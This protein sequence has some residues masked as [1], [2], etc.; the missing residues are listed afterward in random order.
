MSHLLDGILR[1][2]PGRLQT[3]KT[4]QRLAAPFGRILNPD[5][6]IFIIGCYNSGTSLLQAVLA[7][8]P[9]VHG[10]PTEGVALTDALPR[11]EE[12]GWTRMWQ[13]CEE[14]MRVNP[15][16]EQR[17]RRIRRQWSLLYP[18]GSSNLLEKS[19]ANATR[20]P[21][22]EA[23]FRP[24][25]FVYIV[26]N[27][28]AVAEGIRRKARPRQWGNSRYDD[29]YP[30]EL[31]ARQW[32][33]TDEVVTTAKS[34]VDRFLTVRYEAFAEDPSGVVDQITTF[35]S[36]PSL[37]EE[38]LQRSWEVHG[39]D[40]PIRNMNPRSFKNLTDE[41]IDVVTSEAGE[42]LKKYNYI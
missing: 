30:I 33:R 26:R 42:R 25:H 18:A 27:G 5:R 40:E 4:L 22:L 13:A 21:F 29:R 10:L 9:G 8:H 20:I 38:T 32:R 23:Q 31:C 1:P 11:P 39:Y 3:S 14:A 36:L 34:D 24:A 6:W 7:S 17:A 37:P 2:F 15:E 12:E 16:D 35:L 41:E 28:Y 19:I